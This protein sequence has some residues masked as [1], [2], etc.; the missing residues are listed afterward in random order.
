MNGGEIE[1]GSE[2]EKVCVCVC[3][4]LR[5]RNKQS[6]IV[7][8]RMTEKKSGRQ[9]ERVCLRGRQ[10]K[11]RSERERERERERETDRQT[12]RDRYKKMERKR[13]G[14]I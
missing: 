10:K 11:R 7:I 3:L 6:K 2:S 8:E 12:D 9:W 5:E 13:L 1:R 4:C 14:V